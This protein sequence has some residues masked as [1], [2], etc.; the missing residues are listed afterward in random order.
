M[1]TAAGFLRQ[2]VATRILEHLI[3]M[4]RARGYRRLSLE[5]GTTDDYAAAVALYRRHGFEPGPVY[6]SY[7]PSDFNQ[8]FH[9]DL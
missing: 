7:R 2:G 6:G 5:T 4:A 3:A 1:R 8:Y 9:L